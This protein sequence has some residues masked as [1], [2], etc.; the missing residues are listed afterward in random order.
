ML[1]EPARTAVAPAFVEARS[2]QDA[3]VNWIRPVE[4]GQIEARYVRR[5]DD[6]VVVYLSSQ[7]GCRQACRM[8]HLTATG[9]VRLRD[10]TAAEIHEQADVVLAYYR[11]ETTPAR[12]VHFNFMAR[13]EPLAS[14]VLLADADAVLGPLADKA[15]ALNLRPRYLVSTILPKTLSDRALEDVVFGDTALNLRRMGTLRTV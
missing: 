9:Q 7:T 14:A 12:Q 2:R 1:A 6:Y 13:G 10:V 11:A 4:V 3:S 15:V 8:C 5:V